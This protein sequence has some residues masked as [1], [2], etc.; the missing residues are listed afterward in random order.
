MSKIACKSCGKLCAPFTL[1]EAGIC[2]ACRTAAKRVQATPTV[3]RY[4]IE[5]RIKKALAGSDWRMAPDVVEA[6]PAKA[7]RWKVHRADLRALL[8][9]D[10]DPETVTLP[11][12]PE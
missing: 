2:G 1:D 8:N 6:D 5:H 10:F 3:T 12:Q 11:E 7:E 9:S 4:D